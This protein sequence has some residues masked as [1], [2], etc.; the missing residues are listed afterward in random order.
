M[1]G[2]V[3]EMLNAAEGLG[4]Y[5]RDDVQRERVLEHFRFNLGRLAELARGNGVDLIFVVP[6][7]NEKDFAPF[8]SQH[9]PGL[10]P[11]DTSAWKALVSRASRARERGDLVGAVGFARKAVAIDPRYAELQFR[12]GR[13]L[14][15]LGRTPEAVL[16]FERALREDVAPLRA[17]SETRDAVRAVAVQHGVPLVDFEEL[18]RARSPKEAGHRLLGWE[19]FLDHVHPTLDGHRLLARALVDRMEEEGWLRPGVAWNETAAKQVAE[20]HLASVDERDHARAD[21]NLAR[22]LLWL[23]R[24]EGTDRLLTRASEVLGDDAET[25][26][27]QAHVL[28][29]REEFDEA[30][31]LLRR[32]VELKPDYA[33][34]HNSL[35]YAVQKG[36][37]G[38]DPLVHLTEALRLAPHFA[39]ALQNL[40][41]LLDERGERAAA[42]EK[43]RE[44]IAEDPGRPWGHTTLGR[45]L[46]DAGEHE[47]A[48]TSFRHAVSL[49]PDDAHCLQL[50][51]F[52]QAQA[53]NVESAVLSLRRS[54]ELR[55]DDARTQLELAEVLA[56]M[57]QEPE[58]LRRASNAL[59]LAQQQGSPG[60]GVEARALE[61]RIRGV[62]AAP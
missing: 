10:S 55:P 16:S 28:I 51:G 36:G 41:G 15:A 37:Q 53:G 7:S 34:A 22:L 3:T 59:T 6:P 40:T 5:R 18:L 38:S 1:P 23:R 4:Q 32:A 9:S 52:A 47:S 29:K 17:L 27:L 21:R 57:G 8:K 26:W 48:L 46:L 56:G 43:V 30:A 14:L 61:R 13:D 31:R 62:D 11:G 45:F 24:T 25:L 58:A 60:L 20:A 39:D 50:L 54:I 35:G 42:L 19:S 49:A 44:L 33:F 12:L 2:E